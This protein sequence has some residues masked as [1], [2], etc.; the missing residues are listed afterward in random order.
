MPPAQ[1]I[2]KTPTFGRRY[3]CAGSPHAAVAS[4]DAEVQFRC[5]SHCAGASGLPLA[6]S[7]S[8][9]ADFPLCRQLIAKQLFNF[10]ELRFVLYSNALDR[11][12]SFRTSISARCV[13]S[14]CATPDADTLV[15]MRHFQSPF[16]LLPNPARDLTTNLFLVQSLVRPG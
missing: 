16:P 5:Q 6:C 13:P 2:W 4:R 10:N 11:L 8:V 1:L 12:L 14:D 15:L 7:A 3:L 9:D